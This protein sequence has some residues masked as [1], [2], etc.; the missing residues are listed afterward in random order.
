MNEKEDVLRKLSIGE[1]H[2]IECKLAEGGLPENLWE[3]YSSFA[4]TEGGTILLGVK[5]HRESFE[6]KGLSDR[7]MLKYQK[8]FWSIAN[9]KKKV[10]RNILLNH[11]VSPVEINGFK[12]LKIEVPAADRHDKPI[13]IGTDPM[14][15]T[16]RRDFEGDFLCQPEEV[17]AMFADQMD[18]SADSR[19]LENMRLETFNADSVKS[20]RIL[21]ENLHSRHPWNR[22]QD[23]EFLLK[24]S[25]IKKLDN[26]EL[27]PT[28][29]GLLMFG[30]ADSIVQAVP[31]YFLDYREES[32]EKGIRWLFRVTSDDGDW[33]GNLYDFYYK[34]IN[35]VDD[36][37]AVPFANRRNGVRVDE[38][39]VHDAIGEAV[40]NA[41][42]HANF[43]GRQ[44]IVIVKKHKE[45][46]ISNPGTLRITKEEFLAGGNSDPRN[47]II[48]KMFNRIN[49]GERA[50]SGIDKIMTAWKEQNWKMPEFQVSFRP[51]RVTVRLEVGQIVYVP[52]ALDLRESTAANKE[53][54]SQNGNVNDTV[55]SNDI[56]NGN[57]SDSVNGN[58]KQ[59][60]SVNEK[61]IL[62]EIQKNSKVTQNVLCELTGVGKRTVS[63]A[64]KK[65]KDNGMIKRIGSDKNGYWEIQ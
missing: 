36:D 59:Q 60:L 24:L 58:V 42:V 25:A 10:S 28:L 19:V 55:T 20:Y 5:E 21:F 32:N 61:K 11:H 27:V 12:L 50:G 47:P 35:R 13:Y 38:T 46:T 34:I 56:A 41:L 1:N 14:A 64:I 9:D 2:V 44:G 4:N 26:G 3:T 29:A 51:E 62:E 23:D 37:V 22:L 30:N 53:N 49:I 48:L 33:S 63:R 40:A 7:Q 57:V 31:N 54:D 17:R 18:E 43:Y 15:G 45:L 39:A 65:F 8:D 52:E 6:I 16:Y